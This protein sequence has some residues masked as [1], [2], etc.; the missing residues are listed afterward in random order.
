MI[1]PVG[2]KTMRALVVTGPGEAGVQEVAAP[3]AGPGEVVIDVERAGLCGTD[4]EF[5]TGQ[6]AYLHDG[7]ARFPMRLG[8][9]WAGTVTAAGPGVDPGWVGRRVTGDTMLGCGTC[10]RCQGGHQHVCESRQEVGIRSGRA[11]ALAEQLA[12]PAA[13]LHPLPAAVGAALGALVEPG[14]NALRSARGAGLRPGDRAL[15]L[16]PGTI[17]LLAA[18]FA[19]ATGA[20][21]HLMGRSARSLGFARTLGFDGVWT[22][23]EL[24]GLPFDAVIDASNAPA[25]PARA[26]EL[27]EPGGR[28]VYVG[29]A[30]SP[31]LIDT[32]ALALKDV[33]AVGVL[34]ASPG[35]AE[36]I[37][38]YAREAVD[39]RPLIAAT[40]GLG[41]VAAVLA[42]DRPAGAGPGPKIQV[43]PRRE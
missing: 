17:G 4:V 18:M 8:H 19:R 13:A 11:G 38:L 33:T 27:V 29:L 35:L 40:V 31:S 9:E 43:D 14:G 30:G 16:G 24:P 28:V 15:V 34:S 36:T 22:A 37:G 2:A 3:A 21:V 10:R 26:L 25:L 32:R 20:E 6:M 39:P 12:M 42:G 1:G 7:H 23:G 41:G 5:F